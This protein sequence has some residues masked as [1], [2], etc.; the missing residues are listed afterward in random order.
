[1]AQY[2]FSLDDASY[3]NAAIAH[4]VTTGSCVSRDGTRISYRQMGEGPGLVLVHGALQSSRSFTSL[5]AALCD[6]FT[7]YIPDRRGRGRSGPFGDSYAMQTEVE[8]LGALLNKTGS[9]NVFGLSSGAL[10]T[11]E[12][13]LTLPAI[14]K[15][16]LYEPALEIDGQPSPLDWVPRYDKELAAGN[17]PGAMVAIIKGTGDQSLFTSLPRFVLLPMFKLGMRYQS[18][19]SEDD[20][21]SL[22]A[23]VPTVHF[24]TR[25]LMEMAG[26]LESFRTVRPEVLLLGGARSVAFLTAALDALSAILPNCK[27]I[28]LPGLGHIAADNAGEPTRVADELRRYFS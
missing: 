10:I 1:M 8:D 14:H 13:A 27:R 2:E 3:M 21:P 4:Y 5:G 18:K 7:V 24:D 23:L 25:L 19:R 15:I 20:E 9:H 26:R 17:L 11:L 16:A 28:E 12:A 22:Q 6:T